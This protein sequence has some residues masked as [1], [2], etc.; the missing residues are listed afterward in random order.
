MIDDEQL[1]AQLLFWLRAFR[2]DGGAARPRALGR[3][4]RRRGRAGAAGD[5][6]VP[7]HRHRRADQRTTLV[8]R[9]VHRRARLALEVEEAGRLGALAARSTTSPRARE[10]DRHFVLDPEAGRRSRF[11]DGV[12]GRA[13]QI[14]QRIRATG[15]RYGGGARGQRRRRRRCTKIDRDVAASRSS[16]PLPTRGG[17][18]AEPIA[19]GARPHP[20][21]AAPPRPRRDRRAT[22]ASWRSR[23]RAR[24]SGAPSACRASTRAART[25]VAAGVVSV[26]VWPREDPRAPDGAAAGPHDC[27]ARSAAGST[28]AGSSRPSST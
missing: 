27:C 22:S 8:H 21:R 9:P 15:Y 23:R 6:G 4:Q 3:R 7:R 20:R 28:R 10:D 16:N 18:D 12:R 5:A 1:E 11:G 26:V 19:D 2:A 17:A 24:R 14:G 13:P 25:Q